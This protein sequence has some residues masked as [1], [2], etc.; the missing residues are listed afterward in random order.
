MIGGVTVAR[1]ATPGKFCHVNVSKWG[2]PLSRGRTRD[3]EFALNSLWRWLYIII[4]GNNRKPQHWSLQQEQQ[5]SVEE[6]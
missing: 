1:S 6:H 2:N 4:K 3:T 5:V